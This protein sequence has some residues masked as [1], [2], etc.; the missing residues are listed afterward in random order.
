M[1][2]HDARSDEAASSVAGFSAGRADAKH[3]LSR[4]AVANSGFPR[5]AVIG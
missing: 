2:S 4:P 1:V 3:G 5:I